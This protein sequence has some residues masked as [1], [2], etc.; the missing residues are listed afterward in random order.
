M[1][2]CRTIPCTDN[3]GNQWE[4]EYYFSLE[5]DELIHMGLYFG[6]N[7]NAFLERLTRVHYYS[8]LADNLKDILLSSVAKLEGDMLIKHQ[9]I[10]DEFVNSGAYASFFIE[11]L[12]SEEQTTEFL[13][14]IFPEDFEEE[15]EREY[16]DA[17]LLAMDDADFRRIAGENEQYWSKRHTMIYYQRRGAA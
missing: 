11:L 17:E 14:G 4:T 2:V 3:A 13:L 9:G 16:S 8:E 15:T 1:P 7:A 5:E 10:V 6:G 12:E